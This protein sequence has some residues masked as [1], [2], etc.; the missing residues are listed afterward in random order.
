ME[1]NDSTR[2]GPPVNIDKLTIEN[3]YYHKVF[4]T[5]KYQQWTFRSLEPGEDI[6]WE[7]HPETTQFLRVESGYGYLQKGSKKFTYELEDDFADEIVEGTRHR[8][9]V[10]SHYSQPLKLYII[11]SGKILHVQGE[12][13]TRQSKK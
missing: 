13:E 7:V 1:K 9:F 11:Y 4:R 12:I 2:Y 3:E 6:P 10:P 8:I 5:T